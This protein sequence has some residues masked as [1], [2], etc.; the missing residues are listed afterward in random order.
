MGYRHDTS[1]TERALDHNMRMA[2]VPDADELHGSPSGATSTSQVHGKRLDRR[3][4]RLLVG[5]LLAL[6]G[7]ALLITEVAITFDSL[8]SEGRILIAAATFVAVGLMLIGSGLTGRA[9]LLGEAIFAAMPGGLLA[10]IGFTVATY[11]QPFNYSQDFIWIG[12]G[13]FGLLWMIVG[14]IFTYRAKTRLWIRNPRPGANESATI[15]SPQV[16]GSRSRLTPYQRYMILV[17]F[18]GPSMAVLLGY[19][20]GR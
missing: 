13:S 9:S 7:F 3:E 15:P 20:L 8:S 18:V 2:E 5:M 14:P 10:A 11:L 12:L 17:T 16:A 6:I 19:F 1:P 4:L